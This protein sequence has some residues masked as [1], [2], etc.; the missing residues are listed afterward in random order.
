MEIPLKSIEYPSAEKEINYLSEQ[1]RGIETTGKKNED[2]AQSVIKN[3]VATES[4]K[5]FGKNAPE[6][7]TIAGI[8]LKLSPEP[9]DVRMEELYRVL[10]SKGLYVALKVVEK[11]NDPHLEDDFHRFVAE[12]IKEGHGI[13]GLKEKTDLGK[14]I[15]HVLFEIE[16]PKKEEANTQKQDISDLF[17]KME[18]IFTVL[19][20]EEKEKDTIVLELANSAGL[21]TLVFYVSVP[22]AWAN[23]FEAQAKTAYP[24][25][26]ITEAKND[27]NIFTPE[28]KVSI[29]TGVLAET[30]ALPIK[31][32]EAF[33]H[34]PMNQVLG[35]F[36]KLGKEEEGAVIQII[37]GPAS[38]FFAK[39]I[40]HKK[41]RIEKGENPKKVL[42]DKGA[43]GEVL[44]SLMD[45][46]THTKTQK[47][48]IPPNINTDIVNKLNKKLS[49][50]VMSVWLRIAGSAK[51]EKRAE[52]IRLD[53]EATFRQ[54]AE[55][56]GNSFKFKKVS[57][58]N[59]KKA[60]RAIAFR[61]PSFGDTFYLNSQELATIF[62]F[63]SSGLS[64]NQNV[65]TAKT[66]TRKAPV[67]LPNQGTL[68]GVNGDGAEGRNIFLSDEDRLRHLYVVGQTGTGKSTLLKNIVVQDIE[69]GNGVCFIDPHGSDI[70]EILSRIPENRL[71]DVIY[72]DPANL[73]R[74][75]ALNMLEYDTRFPEQKTFVVNELFAIFQK[76][77][78]SVPES[79]G[80]MFEQYFRNAT[81]LTIEDP[82][83]GSTLLHVA[84]VLADKEYR[85]YKLSKCSNPVVI[86]FWR[87]IAS[88]AGGEA[89]L[90][91]I[92][93]YI[94]S[95]FDVFLANDYMRPI[96]AQQNSSLKFREILDNKSILLVNL[97]KGRLGDI[98]SNLL[99]LIVV[100]KIL[101]AAL[102]RVDIDS[103]QRNQFNLVIDEFQNVTTDSISTIFSEARKYKLSLTV[104]HQYIA[105]LNE[106]ITK[107]VFGNV[108]TF[109]A[110]RVGND[111]AEYLEKQFSPEFRAMDLANLPNGVCALKLLANGK[112]QEPFD[113]RTFGF[114]RGTTD[115]LS[116]KRKSAEIFGRP[117]EEV[118]LI[119]QNSFKK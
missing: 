68:L 109:V 76:L 95:K 52:S 98:N 5:L 36:G 71:K 103:S 57:Q 32:F 86:S 33:Q 20:G 63:E 75:M 40:Q 69:K 55:A 51:D 94:T 11:L 90:A 79:M 112:P 34:D 29:S 83:S 53:L 101:M 114:E 104:A 35:A 24:N 74:P 38:S 18:S 115:I 17:Q 12:L 14:S 2:S 6:E 45:L 19:Q 25:A 88:K 87:D 16:I 82:E 30:S 89:S 47:K 59:K 106:N 46:F 28:G 78:G 61:L 42:K 99:G 8:T 23:R 96:I 44:E 10:E 26:K 84:R 67:D 117:K 62:H 80:P 70:E 97:S 7:A 73:E 39:E 66:V 111:D 49:R 13:K 119:I 116:I 93:P 56:G 65:K 27:F 64:I 113:V 107:A 21:E 54:F 60:V 85:E 58:S 92:I 41:E 81:L 91:N 4:V 108:G 105:Q 50:P 102:S 3:Y 31:T 22:I 1:L 15:R 110:F 72:F 100:G 77:Y 9:H 37:Y 48:E 118:E 43:L